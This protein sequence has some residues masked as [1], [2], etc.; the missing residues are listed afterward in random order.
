MD[1]LWD[2]LFFWVG[3]M[4]IFGFYLTGKTPFEL[5]HLHAK[6]VDE[7]GRKMSKSKGNVVSPTEI[8]QKYGADALRMALVYG[9]APA[10][11]IAL[12][13]KKIEAMRNFCN[14]IWN[15]SRFIYINLE[16]PNSKSQVPNKFQISKSKIRKNDKEMLKLLE[17]T[18]KSVNKNLEKYRF[19][20]ALEEI[21]QFF[22]HDFC[23]QYIESVKD[24][25]EEALPVLLEVLITSLK[26]VHP[27]APFVTEAIYQQFK[28]VLPNYRLTEPE[29]LIIAPWPGC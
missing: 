18:V 3:R 28:K 23:D 1:T 11:N 25:K 13:E 17:K 22:W 27:F 9:V 24:R 14:K 15:A 7:K 4:M 21:Y 16:T 19:G 10:S 2:I 26:L 6:V 29:A 20:Q 5:V 8:Y 12:S